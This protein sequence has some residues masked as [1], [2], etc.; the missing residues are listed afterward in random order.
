MADDWNT[1]Q[2]LTMKLPEALLRYVLQPSGADDI[3]YVSQ[4]CLKIWELDSGQMQRCPQPLWQAIYPDDRAVVQRL[5]Q[6]SA[7][8]LTPWFCA[9]RIATPSGRQKWLQGMG[10]PERLANGAVAC[11]QLATALPE[12]LN[13]TV[14]AEG[15]ETREQMQY[16]QP[17]RG[18]GGRATI[19]LGPCR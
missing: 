12:Q 4:G 14:V 9:W 18:Q 3:T 15:S 11:G 17:H 8:T 13:L 10:Q 7:D 1:T 16:L 2:R 5:L 6:Q 19:F